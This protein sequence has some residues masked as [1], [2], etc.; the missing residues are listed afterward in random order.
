MK[1]IQKTTDMR[2]IAIQR[3]GVKDVR[4]P[5]RIKTLS[6]GEQ[7]VL[8]TIQFTVALPQEYKGTHM[9]RFIEILSRWQDQPLAEPEMEAILEEALEKLE[10]ESADLHIAFTYFVE[11]CAPVSGMKS[12]LDL[13]CFFHGTKERGE[14]MQFRLGVSVPATSLCPCSKEISA[15]GAHNQRSRLAVAAEFNAETPCIY[16]ENLAKLMEEEASSPV[17]PL[18]KR[19]DEKYVTEYA[20]DH[21][22]FVEDILRD[23]VLRMRG[24]EGMRWFSVDCENFESIHNHNAFAAHEEFVK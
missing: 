15:Y 8:A 11:K 24:I 16:I 7:Q 9:S 10:A 20:Y 2:G 14:A 21:P 22:K 3:V 6:G 5:F 12:V 4:L 18:L 1:D 13:D 19:T 17:Y 23:L